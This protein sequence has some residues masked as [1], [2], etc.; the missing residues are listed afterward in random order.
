MIKNL[1]KTIASALILST[2]FGVVETYSA[3]ASSVNYIVIGTNTVLKD[4]KV[5]MSLADAITKAIANDR[6]YETIDAQIDY[7]KEQKRDLINSIGGITVPTLDDLTTTRW[8]DSMT[9]TYATTI[10]NFNSSIEQLESQT[11]ILE[12]ATEVSIRNMFSG[13]VQNETNLD[14]LK[15][16][17]ELEQIS[18]EQALIKLDFGQVSQSSVDQL[19]SQLE[20]TDMNIA[21]L[22]TQIEQ[23]YIDLNNETGQATKNRYVVEKL[24][25]LEHYTLGNFTLPQFISNSFK[26]DTDV[27]NAQNAVDQALINT[28]YMADTVT[29]A[30]IKLYDLELYN[31]KID[32]LNIKSEKEIALQDA[33]NSL[34][35]IEQAYDKALLDIKIAED[36]F[37]LAEIN[38]NAGNITE[39]TLKQTELAVV[40][41]EVALEQLIYNYDLQVFLFEHSSLL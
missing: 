3:P 38:Y 17:R 14:L 7:L 19:K 22:Q 33:Y 18:Y 35:L 39:L 1:Q 30:D 41:S 37:K 2:S 9:H 31:A 10:M 12:L 25:T 21:Q 28:R 40:Q 8:V 29:D 15:K 20:Q 24:E 6:T 27:V 5:Y 11:G 34:T 32:L 23:L 13:I 16:S 4:G 36:N 26:L